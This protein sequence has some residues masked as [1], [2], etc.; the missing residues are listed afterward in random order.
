[1][2]EAPRVTVY[3]TAWC[4]YCASLKRRLEAASIGYREIDIEEQP[5]YGRLI[6]RLTGGFRTVPTV[7]VC[8]S[9]LVNPSLDEIVAALAACDTYS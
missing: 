7:E 3:T 1:M 2:Q 5:H 6:E 4:G 8:G 9:Y